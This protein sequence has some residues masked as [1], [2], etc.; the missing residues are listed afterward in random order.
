[1]T[2]SCIFLYPS[3]WF[4]GSINESLLRDKSLWFLVFLNVFPAEGLTPFSRM[5]SFQGC[6]YSLG[7][8]RWCFPLE[9]RTSWFYLHYNVNDGSLWGKGRAGLL[10]VIKDLGFLNS[11]FL[12]W[13]ASNCVCTS[14][15]PL[16]VTLWE[17]GLEEQVQMLTL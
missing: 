8:H 2:Y 3:N 1:M 6:L 4:D 11:E 16:S 9:Q 7:R 12:S 15:D 14:W 17:L 13:N 10:L 5:L